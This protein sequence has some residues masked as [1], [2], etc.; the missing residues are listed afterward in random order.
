MAGMRASS[1][2]IIPLI[3]CG[4]QA[5]RSDEESKLL[6]D[7]HKRLAKFSGWAD[8]LERKAGSTIRQDDY[9]KPQPHTEIG[10]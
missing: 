4:H 7:L 5:R 3:S 1:D 10:G 6:N 2:R 8:R 9:G